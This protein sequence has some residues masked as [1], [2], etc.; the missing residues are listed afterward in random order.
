[1]ANQFG[2]LFAADV[3]GHGFCSLSVCG[4]AGAG[5]DVPPVGELDL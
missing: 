1:L 3:F 4:G 5:V 2:G